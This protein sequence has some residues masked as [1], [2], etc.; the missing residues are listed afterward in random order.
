MAPG[1]V[2]PFDEDDTVPQSEQI[3]MKCCQKTRAF[4]RDCECPVPQ[5]PCMAP[6]IVFTH[7]RPECVCFS[8]EWLRETKLFYIPNRI[9]G[10]SGQQVQNPTYAGGNTDDVLTKDSSH[11]CTIVH[12]V[13]LNENPLQWEW[14]IRPGDETQLPFLAPLDQSSGVLRVT[15][16]SNGQWKALYANGTCSPLRHDTRPFWDKL[17]RDYGYAQGYSPYGPKGDSGSSL[18]PDQVNPADYKPPRL[19]N[20]SRENSA[21]QNNT[22]LF[23][24]G[25]NESVTD[26]KLEQ[27]FLQFGQITY[28]NRPHQ[29]SG[30]VQFALR[31][32]ALMA[33]LQMQGVPIYNCRL[34]ISWGDPKVKNQWSIQ[35][36]A[37]QRPFKGNKHQH[38]QQPQSVPQQMTQGF[39]DMPGPQN[40][41]QQYGMPEWVYAPVPY[42]FYYL[43]QGYQYPNQQ[44]TGYCP[45]HMAHP[46][47][48]PP[49][50]VTAPHPQSALPQGAHGG[51]ASSL[52]A[53]VASW[54]GS[55]NGKDPVIVPSDAVPNPS[56]ESHGQPA[57]RSNSASSLES[58]Q[59][60][61][62]SSG[63][64]KDTV[65][66]LG[67]S[68][69][70]VRSMEERYT[71][72]TKS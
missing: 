5:G 12:P 1:N 13:L 70:V 34:R 42:T 19:P 35:R 52:N 55:L 71:Y 11:P 30:F 62:G 41:Q 59:Q 45:Q 10:R 44:Q 63:D 37:G 56:Q 32:D 3:I 47:P 6:E 65:A 58:N 60:T 17:Y 8:C 61:N 23:I 21:A 69:S 27:L 72:D 28:V 64:E 68:V 15:L 29:T 57:P 26:E 20:K 7:Y 4:M 36:R 38:L 24:G 16:D 31:R 9:P 46:P 48:P 33:M 40:Q 14:V 22:T 54:K 43:G 53:S 67:Q 2:T 51:H 18:T 25:I 50:P 39:N 49:A 66:F